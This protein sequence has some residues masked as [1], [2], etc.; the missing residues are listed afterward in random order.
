MRHFDIIENIVKLINHDFEEENKV[1]QRANAD[2]K[3]RFN[4]LK[5][6]IEWNMYENGLNG[7]SCSDCGL[8]GFSF[9]FICQDCDN[10]ICG[11]CA[12]GC[13]VCGR[14]CRTYTLF[15][16]LKCYRDKGSVVCSYCKD[17]MD[18]E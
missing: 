1:L 14:S 2:L 8:N 10:F 18:S 11:R 13:T 6:N 7:I 15:R 16:C 9:S 17:E 5:Y 4:D 12:Q 3:R